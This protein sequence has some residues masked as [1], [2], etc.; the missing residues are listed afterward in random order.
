MVPY[1][2][3]L[4]KHP[5][6]KGVLS[7]MVEKDGFRHVCHQSPWAAVQKQ[8]APDHQRSNINADRVSRGSAPSVIVKDI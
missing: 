1:A 2:N 6:S 8:A 5:G 7:D 3:S 4:M